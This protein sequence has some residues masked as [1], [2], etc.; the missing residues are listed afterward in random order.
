MLSYVKSQLKSLGNDANT[1]EFGHLVD[2]MCNWNRG[3]D[4]M[5]FISEHVL[6][7][8]AVHQQLA[9]SRNSTR[10]MQQKLVENKS[11]Y[12]KARIV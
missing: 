8:L 4:L 1:K 9:E 2:V 7:S 10:G 11:A 12:S 6:G 5:E 3:E